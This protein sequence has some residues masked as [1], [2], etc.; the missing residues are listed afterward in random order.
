LVLGLNVSANDPILESSVRSGLRNGGAFVLM[1]KR[2]GLGGLGHVINAVALV[3][4]LSVANA[5]LYMTVKYFQLPSLL[6]ESN[7][8]CSRTGR[9]RSKVSFEEEL[10]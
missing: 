6:P 4:A 5:N 8:L 1:M 3:A 7:S 2:A 10:L 9:A